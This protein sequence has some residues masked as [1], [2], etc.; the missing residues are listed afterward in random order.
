MKPKNIKEFQALVK[1]YETI[2]LD[3]IKEVWNG[4]YCNP[5]RGLTGFGSKST[6]S[7][8]NAALKVCVFCVYGPA[9]YDSDGELESFACVGHEN[10][11]SYEGIDNASTPK[12]LLL[13]YR[14]RAK[15]L[16]KTYSQY[17]TDEALKEEE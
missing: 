8:C 5:A 11:E 1:R 13:A 9:H 10:F 7:L 16:R 3:E 17:L 6:C 15:H 2:T 4:K 14:N 12:E